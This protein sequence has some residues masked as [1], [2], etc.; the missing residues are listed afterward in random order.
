[1]LV[2]G[3]CE[4]LDARRIFRADVDIEQPSSC[5]LRNVPINGM[6][7]RDRD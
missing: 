5:A 7:I 3:W 2:K 6:F 1:M 4:D